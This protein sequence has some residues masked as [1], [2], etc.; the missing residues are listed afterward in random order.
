MINILATVAAIVLA[1]LITLW[2]GGKLQ[3]REEQRRVKLTLLGTLI[4]LR[5]DPVHAD[6]VRALNLIDVAFVED[7][8]VRDAWTRYYASLTD[9]QLQNPA[10]WAVR[11]ERRRDLL[12]A[13]V[14]SVKWKGKISTADILRTYTPEFVHKQGLNS[15]MEVEVKAE[16]YRREMQRLGLRPIVEAPVAEQPPA[17]SQSP[18]PAP[19]VAGNGSGQS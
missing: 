19:H 5:H 12:S 3:R 1:P 18:V 11:E 15:V 2:I 10:G 17:L 7:F 6:V 4:G 9:Q 13:M 8:L 14:E 16:T